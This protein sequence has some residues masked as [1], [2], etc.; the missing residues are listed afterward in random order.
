[1]ND[2][3]EE[4]LVKDYS[5]WITKEGTSLIFDGLSEEE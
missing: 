5:N 1:M 2:I 4:V 3:L